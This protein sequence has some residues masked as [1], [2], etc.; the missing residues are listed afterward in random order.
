[1]LLIIVIGGHTTP[2]MI[3]SNLSCPFC[4]FV[5]SGSQHMEKN[6]ETK[7][8][9]FKDLGI[10]PQ[11]LAVLEKMGFTIPTPIQAK[12]IP[13]GIVGKDIV[14]IA[15]TGTGK[16][17]AFG[18]PMI[19]YLLRG[20]GKGLVILPTR[21]L[22][23]QVDEEF[24]K[25]GEALGLKTAVLIGGDSMG[26]QL[27]ALRRNPHVLIATPGRLAD[28]FKQRYV[29][30]DQVKMVVL[31]EADRMLDMGFAPQITQ[32]LSNVPVSRQT[33]LFSA[34]MP[35][36][37]LALATKFMQLPLRIE[38]A[39]AGTSSERVA[40]EIIMV[41]KESKFVLLQELLEEYKG[42]V[43]V[44]SRTKH[45]AKKIT[46]ALTDVGYGAAEIHSNRTLVQRR[47]ALAG[48]KNGK[49]RV[50]VATD[51]AARGI[52]VTG[53]ELVVNFD[54]PDNSED[55]VHRIGR[56]GRA[57]KEGKAVS[58]ATPDQGRDIRDI[59]RLIRK[60]LPV[61]KH[62][63]VGAENL[64][65][66]GSSVGRNFR[67][68][69]GGGGAGRSSGAPSGGNFRRSNGPAFATRNRVGSQGGQRRF[70]PSRP[71]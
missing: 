58:F 19:Q 64:S 33:M 40:Q 10:S 34:T 37:I 46:H 6:I 1:M 67:G 50:L 21:E 70:A 59:E 26:R 69:R 11:I 8:L 35:A 63:S 47:A 42:T 68:G 20:E 39:P 27:Q 22:A 9:G 61:K 49:Y 28:H 55:Y 31:D 32:I 5:G 53:I 23:I 41:K 17:L 2:Q 13:L 29:K 43:L 36:P 52:D 7:P 16:T 45:G 14:G 15:Q 57:G 62:A 24:R 65:F 12:S 48:F 4:D 3:D 44:F 56:T 25:I 54:L 51:I 71:R 66:G 38:V 30:F 18:I 60:T